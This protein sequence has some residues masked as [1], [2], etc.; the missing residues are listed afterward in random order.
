M[1]VEDDDDNSN[2]S[3]KSNDKGDKDG[4]DNFSDGN[5]TTNDKTSKSKDL[6]NLFVIRICISLTFYF[7]TPAILIP[8]KIVLILILIF[9]STMK[10]LLKRT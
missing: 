8:P 7:K 4:D 6:F 9:G 2:E 1:N 10:M 3:L 5:I